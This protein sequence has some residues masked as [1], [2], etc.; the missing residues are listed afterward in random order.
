MY[1]LVI[2]PN[3]TTLSYGKISRKDIELSFLNEYPSLY[4]S[5]FNEEMDLLEENIKRILEDCPFKSKD[6][7]LTLDDSFFEIEKEATYV[8]EGLALDDK[9]RKTQIEINNFSEKKA[10]NFSLRASFL[11][12]LKELFL[13][14]NLNLISIKSQTESALRFSLDLTIETFFISINSKNIDVIFA[15][16]LS[17]IKFFSLPKSNFII[18]DK[19]YVL[20]DI[21]A[22][23]NTHLR[24]KDSIFSE[25]LK[26]SI[27]SSQK[28]FILNYDDLALDK[29]VNNLEIIT[30]LKAL[31]ILKTQIQEDILAK[32]II[33]IG[34]FLSLL[35]YNDKNLL[36][37]P[38]ISLNNLNF[39]KKSEPKKNK[40]VANIP[41]L[42]FCKKVSIFCI[43]LII[44]M[45]GSI[46]YF[47]R[48]FA[49][50]SEMLA[51]HQEI[52]KENQQLEN[53][54]AIY[55]NQHMDNTYFKNIIDKLKIYA[56]AKD[57]ED[58][59]LQ[60]IDISFNKDTSTIIEMEITGSLDE[61][62]KYIDSIKK[63]RYF[64]SIDIVKTIE[65]PRDDDNDEETDLD[66]TIKSSKIEIKA[67]KYV[68]DKEGNNE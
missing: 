37:P 51:K 67:P 9:D 66:A 43:I 31:K 6:I 1:S 64:E 2:L 68:K 3:K 24:G 46:Y 27:G 12:K 35:K 13:K 48:I 61:V 63:D 44:F 11:D 29:K 19:N 50:T 49:P 32:N 28:L 36:I 5:L 26:T 15:S 52:L 53:K 21:V 33:S 18:D 25:K 65:I 54:I 58:I 47:N 38:G 45:L 20:A 57:Y 10:I 59:K 60:N 23:L 30:K 41:L 42:G 17:G 8:E 56:L 55:E 16:S 7:I 34:T 40:E 4:T 62:Q 22:E 39:L 14:L